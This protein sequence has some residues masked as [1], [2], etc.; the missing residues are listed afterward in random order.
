MEKWGT[1][2]TITFFLS[3]DFHFR[4]ELF[5]SDDVFRE[6]PLNARL[7]NE[8]CGEVRQPRCRNGVRMMHAFIVYYERC[9]RTLVEYRRAASK[10]ERPSFHLQLSSASFRLHACSRRRRKPAATDEST[11]AASGRRVYSRRKTVETFLWRD[12]KC[13]AVCAKTHVE[14]HEHANVRSPLTSRAPYL[15][16]KTRNACQTHFLPFVP[17]QGPQGTAYVTTRSRGQKL[18]EGVCNEPRP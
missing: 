15:K 18:K 12:T 8:P 4:G 16:N 3:F 10:C 2:P 17:V 1:F 13:S 6:A 5:R 9:K 7:V 11:S 14:Y